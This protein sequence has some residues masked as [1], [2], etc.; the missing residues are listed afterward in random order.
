MC[1]LPC[2]N[3]TFVNSFLTIAPR[4]VGA[5]IRKGQI[6]SS[7]VHRETEKVHR[8]NAARGADVLVRASGKC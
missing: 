8:A 3:F 2:D 5:G 7:R 1:K 6:S 4:E